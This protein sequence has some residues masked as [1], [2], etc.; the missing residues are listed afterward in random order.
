MDT[1]KLRFLSSLV[2]KLESQS[3]ATVAAKSQGK[4]KVKFLEGQDNE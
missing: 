2:E 1:N 4:K 3:D